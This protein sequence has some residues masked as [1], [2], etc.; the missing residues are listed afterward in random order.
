MICNT[1]NGDLSFDNIWSGLTTGSINA[2]FVAIGI[3]KVN[4][5]FGAGDVLGGY[6]WSSL[7]NAIAGSMSSL[8]S[9]TGNILEGEDFSHTFVKA[10]LSS[11]IQAI[12]SGFLGNTFSIAASEI[13]G[14]TV[15]DKVARQITENILGNG[16]CGY[17]LGTY[18]SSLAGDKAFPKTS[19][20]VN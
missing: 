17:L 11:I 3:P 7:Y 18:I 16:M 14:N 20:T 12:A 13:T 6:F 8:L 19:E 1:S 5:L 2:A 4:A 10:G 15:T 9:S